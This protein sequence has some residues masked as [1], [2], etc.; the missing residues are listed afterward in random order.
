MRRATLLF[1]FLLALGGS[2]IAYAAEADS[3]T[4]IQA[5]RQAGIARGL[6]TV[7]GAD[8]PC[9]LGLAQDGGF[10]V[11]VIEAQE[12]AAAGLRAAAVEQG[13]DI[14]HLVVD[15][16]SLES[17]PYADNLVDAVLAPGAGETLGGLPAAEIRRVLRPGGVLLLPAQGDTGKVGAWAKDAG[18]EAGDKVEGWRCFRKAPLAGADDW[19]HWEHGPDNNPASMDAHVRAPYRTQW[20]APPYYIAMP[21]VTTAAGGRTFLA[22]GHIAHHEREEPWLNTL[23]ARNG[24]NGAELWRRDLPDGYMVHRSAFIATAETFYMID[25]NGDGCLLLD[26]ETGTEKGRIRSEGI[27]GQ[28]KWIA[29]EGDTLY[30]LA[31][32]ERDPRETTVVRSLQPAWSWSELSPGYYTERVPWG[33]GETIAAFDAPG[34]KLRWSHQET[35]RVDSRAMAIGGGRVFFYGPDARLG[36]L[37]A[38]TGKAVWMNE[39]QELRKLIEEPGRGLVSTPGFRSTC[40]CVYTPPA[41]VFAPQTNMNVVAVSPADGKLLWHRPKTSSNANAVFLDD[42]LYIGIG[43]EGNTLALDPVTGETRRDLGFRKRSCAR[44][45]ATPESLFCR[46]YPEGITRYD[47][48]QQQFFFDGSMRPACNDG[49]LGANGLLYIGPWLCD[50]NLTLIGSVA[51]ASADGF[52]P[53]SMQGERVNAPV[54]NLAPTLATASEK[55]WYAYR[56]GNDHSGSA[57]VNVSRILFPLWRWQPKTKFEASP[58][59]AAYGLVFSS[60]LDGV[61]RA[62][63]AETGLLQWTFAT[64]GPIAQPPTLWKG[65]AFVGSGDGY[66]YAL[67]AASGKLLWKFRAAPVERRIMMYDALCS[68]WPVNSGVLVHNGV[69]YF[70]AGLVDYDGTYVYGVNAETGELV[71]VNNS[72]GHLDKTLRKGVSAQGN[73]TVFGDYLWLAGGNVISPAPYRLDTGAY[74]GPIPRDGSPE[75]NRGE[76]LGVFLDKGLV[77]GGRLRYS[78]SDN[79]VNPGQFI[80]ARCEKPD[81]VSGPAFSAG[82]V[83]PAWDAAHAVAMPGRDVPPAGYDSEALAGVFGRASRSVPKR[84][85]DAQRLADR[86]VDALALAQDAV[87]ALCRT[88]VARSLYP[89]YHVC[90]L[91]RDTGALMFQHELPGAPRLNGLAI[92]RDGRVLVTLDDGGVAAFGSLDKLRTS[93]LQLAQVSKSGA[94]DAAEVGKRLESALDMVHDPEGRTF[95]L[96]SLKQQGLDLPAEARRNGSVTDWNLLGPVPWNESGFP[97]DK[98]L[99]GEPDIRLDKPCKVA[100]QQLA[101][102]EYV[103][104]DSSGKVDLDGIFG[105]IENAAVYAYAEVRLPAAGDYQMKVGSND[106]FKCWFNGQEAARFDGGRSYAPDQTVVTVP[107]KTGVNKILVKITQL[108]GRWAFGVRFTDA[109]GKDLAIEQK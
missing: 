14:H 11:H 57:A 34:G 75:T 100:G 83:A 95:L 89:Q 78:A 40:F 21:A 26:P 66:V 18:L 82:Q 30:V 44:L 36:A 16:Q 31:G 25:P 20:L 98:A 97:T 67:E 27:P 45:T 81:K 93:V 29:L 109:Q 94:V 33:F 50:C 19:S 107:G 3:G 55:D 61:V 73:L 1:G 22:M 43:E 9:A 2:E 90:L 17:L 86:R 74:A 12:A 80:L 106:G 60:G 104:A 8:G 54:D 28:W 77:M 53:E 71:W 49:V 51:W 38:A 91:D 62:L 7:L 105:A 108:G 103:S 35:A 39:E 42:T 5:L 10:L 84:L 41:L 13:L 88:P 59:T 56:G 47:R 37:D 79:V 63:D 15:Q 23:L 76:E 70:A 58:A 46:G 6:C 85:W 32:V 87:V 48:Q 99:V 102:R 69:A 24:Y 65:R 101:W 72:S 92:D 4:A 96:A 52:E 68:T 64:G